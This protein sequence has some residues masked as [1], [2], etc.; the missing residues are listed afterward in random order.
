M[1]PIRII[2]RLDIK[3]EK[4]IKGIHLEGWRLI[5]NPNE[6]SK[7]YYD[8]GID[9]IIYID[10]VANLYNRD[11]LK[12]IIE[13]TSQNIFVPLT[14]GG[15]IRSLDDAYQLLKAGADKVAINTGAIKNP[16]LITEIAN[17]FGSQCV[18]SSI[19]AKRNGDKKWE[20]YID[21]GREPT[22]I[23][24]KDL[25]K[26]AISLGAGELLVTSVD[27]DGTGNGYDV[28]LYKTISSV[29]TVPL[30][31]CGGFGKCEDFGD[32]TKNKIVDAVAIAS[33]LHYDWTSVNEIRKYAKSNN[34]KVREI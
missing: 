12:S 16:K 19:Q 23:D 6:Y 24:V 2:A 18:V 30:I 5:G 4:L 3:G 10:A 1:L 7:K 33:A 26:K 29:S 20:A 14:V 13:N 17:R 27:N 8:H 21:S 34:I 11:I 9:E 25:A 31:A 32:V 15:G 22:G 28:D